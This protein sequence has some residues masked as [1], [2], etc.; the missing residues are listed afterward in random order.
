MITKELLTN[1]Y[2]KAKDNYESTKKE[3]SDTNDINY[4]KSMCSH[5]GEMIICK[6]LLKVL[7]NE[8]SNE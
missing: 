6:R 4:L 3:Y 8:K 2:N 5:S 1:L 7:E